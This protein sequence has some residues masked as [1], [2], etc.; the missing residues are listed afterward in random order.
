VFDVLLDKMHVHF[1]MYGTNSTCN[2]LLLQRPLDVL[3]MAY[4]YRSLSISGASY[5][6]TLYRSVVYIVD[7]VL[8]EVITQLCG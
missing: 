4:V 1:C 7:A 6:V 3:K 2:T 8:L 5:V